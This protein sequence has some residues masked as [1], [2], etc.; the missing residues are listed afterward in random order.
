MTTYGDGL[1]SVKGLEGPGD[2]FEKLLQTGEE[3]ALGD[4]TPDVEW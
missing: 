2:T 1:C 4:E 3:M